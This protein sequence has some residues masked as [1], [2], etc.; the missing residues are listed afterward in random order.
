MS[1]TLRRPPAPVEPGGAYRVLLVCS[2]GG[3]LAQLEQLRP[4][5]SSLERTWVCPPTDDVRSTLVGEDVVEG[6]HPTTRNLPNLL[7]NVAL[8]VRTI[9]RVRP[10]VVV[11]DGAG[12]AV[13]FF[14]AAR[15]AGVR[16]AYLEVYDRV[17]GPTLTTRL[18]RPVCDLLMVQWPDQQAALPGSVLAGPVL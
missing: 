5:W 8:A 16:T 12:L 13:P 17:D 2:S 6:H 15:A 1:A 14:W 4:W 10:D 9:R 3:H 11:S 18:V 7:R